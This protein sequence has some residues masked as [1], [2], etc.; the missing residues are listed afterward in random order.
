VL[1]KREMKSLGMRSPDYADSWVTLVELGRKKHKLSAIYEVPP[2]PSKKPDTSK[3][4][5]FAWGFKKPERLRGD[6]K[7]N[8]ASSEQGKMNRNLS[9]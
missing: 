4:N 5:P 3:E 6:V 7:R 9:G 8:L 2:V 1:S